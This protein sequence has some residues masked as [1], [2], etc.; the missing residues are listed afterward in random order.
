MPPLTRQPRGARAPAAKPATLKTRAIR[1]LARREHSRAEL[2]R[3]L[4]SETEDEAVLE[5]LLDELEAK[6]LLSDR[7]YTEVLVRGAAARQGV[8]RIARRLDEAGV[9]RGVSA[10]LLARLKASEPQL[11]YALWSRRF[12]QLPDSPQQK[13]RQ[14]RFLLQRG[15]APQVVRDV[16]RRAAQAPG[17]A[18]DESRACTWHA[19]EDAWPD[20]AA[21]D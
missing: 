20:D 14:L 2:R 6:A 1:H 15:F 18:P 16:W 5:A 17:D 12:G 19:D 8:A 3:K 9:E 10:P 21:V 7:R 4:A 11:A 13:A